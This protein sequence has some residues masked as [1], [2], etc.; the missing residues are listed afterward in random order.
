MDA[1][2]NVQ[3]T[4]HTARGAKYTGTIWIVEWPVALSRAIPNGQMKRG[5]W[6]MAVTHLM[7]LLLLLTLFEYPTTAA[8]NIRYVDD[9]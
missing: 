7:L 8:V 1:P 3:F 6:R 5:I 4:S 9:E 2:W